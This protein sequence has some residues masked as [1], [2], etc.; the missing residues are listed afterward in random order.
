MKKLIFNPVLL[1]LSISWLV[2]C[3]RIPEKELATLINSRPY[4]FKMPYDN[5]I[6]ILY[7]IP[8]DLPFS[9]TVPNNGELLG[10]VEDHEHQSGTILLKIE[11]PPKDILAYFTNLLAGAALTN[12]NES[13]R[14]QVFFPPDENGATFCHEQ[15]IAVILEIFELENGFNDVRLHYT[16]DDQ[17]IANTTCGQP[18]LDIGDF[19]FPYL[20]APSNSS[21]TGGGGGGGGGKTGTIPGAQGYSVEVTIN[22]DDNLKTICDHYADL[23]ASEGWL[24]LNQSSTENSW[25][26][27]WDFGY[28][29][30]R[31]W[32]ARL[33][34]SANE[35]PN[36]YTIQLQAVSP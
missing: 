25:E 27:N 18:I 32:L 15:S 33:T 9:F 14:Y 3:A 7:S 22:S 35:I 2:G 13:L 8:E 31:S 19:P 24:L 26:S 4:V 16:T 5:P 23:L 34:V 17:V 6:Y 20:A 30:T 36:Q 12:I 21:V 29:E 28:Y 11:Q 1:L 10:T